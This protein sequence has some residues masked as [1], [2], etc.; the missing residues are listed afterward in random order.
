M[1]KLKGILGIDHFNFKSKCTRENNFHA[2]FCNY[3]VKFY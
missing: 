2:I 3:N 1:D